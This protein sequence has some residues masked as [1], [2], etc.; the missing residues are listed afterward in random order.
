MGSPINVTDTD[1]KSEV[2]Q[3]DKP[4]L[5]D[6]WAVWCGPCRMIAPSIKEIA[7]EYDAE[8]KVA[9][10]DVDH[11]PQTAGRYGVMSIPTMMVF[12]NGQVVERIVGAMPKD[13]ILSH[14]LPHV[15]AK[16]TQA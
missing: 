11:N 12:K 6:F 5:V 13:R 3:S 9:K 15:D 1:F 7:A 16:K 2:L 14:V 10:L 4:V 8:L